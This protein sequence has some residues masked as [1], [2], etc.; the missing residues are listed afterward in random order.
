MP[1]PINAGDC[2]NAALPT[3]N[4]CRHDLRAKRL[5]GRSA[6]FAEKRRRGA[7]PTT[8]TTARPPKVGPRRER[9]PPV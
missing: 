9:V 1:S 7:A 4:D 3:R 6:A 5:S 2:I 8:D